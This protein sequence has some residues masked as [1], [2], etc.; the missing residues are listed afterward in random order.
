MTLQPKPRRSLVRSDPGER[1]TVRRW[2]LRTVAFA[3]AASLA[4][5][6]APS[7][8][9]AP[10]LLVLVKQLAKDA[11]QSILKDL[12]LSSLRDMGC[13]GIA[14]ANAFEAF[15]LRKKAGGGAG[16]AGM[17]GMAAS[18]RRSARRP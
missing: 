8:A 15:D 13:K 5:A 18:L 1:S 9:I 17:A 7:E 4:A 10:V 14:L 3:A 6:P 16:M 11:A 12:L 2:R